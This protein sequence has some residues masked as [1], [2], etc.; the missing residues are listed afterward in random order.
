MVLFNP[1]AQLAQSGAVEGKKIHA[2]AFLAL[3]QLCP[4]EYPNVLVYRRQREFLRISKLRDRRGPQTE[5][6][7]DRPAM[8]VPKCLERVI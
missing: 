2:S 1:I 3:Y 5:V 6:M 7:H 4:L 8:L